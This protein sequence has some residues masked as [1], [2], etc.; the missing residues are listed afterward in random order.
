MTALLT[1]DDMCRL[2]ERSGLLGP[3]QLEPYRLKHSTPESLAQL[4]LRDKLLTPLQASNLLRGRYRGFFLTEKYKILALLGAGGMGRVLLCE[5]LI[6]RKLVA[7]KLLALPKERPANADGSRS[8]RQ[9]QAAAVA[10]S[11]FL[12]EARV[13]ASLDDPHIVR[14][15]DV[16]RT[17]STPFI[18]M[19][20][21]DGPN[22][23][24]LVE[25]HGS[26]TLERALVY[27]R[28]AAH[29]LAQVYKAGLVHR[30]V[31]PANL[32]LERT[33]MV[34]LSD[35]GLA[36]F[37]TPEKDDRLTER[38]DE[39][40]VVLG[41]ADFLAPEQALS[42]PKV[43]IRADIYALGCTLFYLLSGQSVFGDGSTAQKL[44]WHQTRPPRAIQELC[45]SVPSELSALLERMLQKDPAARY[46]TP[47]ELLEAL[48]PWAAL[49]VPPPAR[50]EVG[51]PHY[52]SFLLGLAPPVNPDLIG[53][54]DA[55]NTSS[56]VAQGNTPSQ[57]QSDTASPA[58]SA[59]WPATI[60]HPARTVQPS[61]KR[62][63]S[64]R[65]LFGLVGGVL[66]LAVL[67][68]AI[69]VL[70]SGTRS[71]QSIPGQPDPGPSGA[72][73][74]STPKPSATP[75][76]V[77][78]R[79]GG[80]TFVAPLMQHWAT[81]YEKESRGR[82]E[83]K[84]MGSSK[85]IAGMSDLFLDFGCTD[86]SM[87]DEQLTR[88]KQNHGEVIHIPLALGAVV[89]T[90]NLPA[91]SRTLRFTGPLLADIFLGK[92]TR[93][94]DPAIVVNNPG[95][96]LPDLPISVVHRSEGSGTTFI[97]TDYLTKVSAQWREKVGSGT[98]VKWPVGQEGKGN[99]G[100][101]RVVSQTTGA[102]GY[103]ELTYALAEN[104]PAGHVKNRE[105]VFVAPALESVTAAAASLE[106]I[107]EDLRFT[108]TDAPGQAAYPITGS[109][110][111]VLYLD[112]PADKGAD[113]ARFFHWAT[114][115]G[116]RHM[117]ELRYAPLPASVVQKI[118]V[119]L[120][121]IQGA[122]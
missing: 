3:A 68:G 100:V 111:A 79:G 104:L 89:P 49:Q 56:P 102:I 32:L 5:H 117:Q 93:W 33:G 50:W 54:P 58:D 63:P 8:S 61:T 76:G 9:L 37:F 91:T 109:V 29:A 25:K 103:V 81:L 23:Q 59:E 86:A 55:A 34:K 2:I 11:R 41:S 107:P 64:R 40:S 80:S 28:Q 67:G 69:G 96:T 66:V 75:S 4:L 99:D 31:K 26:L 110:W 36:R 53:L 10:E 65:L 43:D 101:V 44:I 12:R 46:Q 13:A 113:L 120:K 16:E 119:K 85:G 78:L 21:V 62:G 15:Y 71:N 105:G 88:A 70:S 1:T 77:S 92:I 14:V 114:H 48:S 18:V 17:D 42:S 83:Y 6:L 19:E 35:L 90:Y 45:P 51:G 24:E 122:R 112:Q 20:F 106:K 30:D 121:R 108:L 115:E 38:L 7:V 72:E 95:Q 39:R 60:S 118:E 57:S 73:A 94:N 52:R 98:T 27:T 74:S 116:Q 84:G 87:T 22:L 82:I 47:T 97:W